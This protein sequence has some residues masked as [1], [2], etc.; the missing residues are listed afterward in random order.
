MGIDAEVVPAETKP[1]NDIHSY[2]VPKWGTN[3]EGYVTFEGTETHMFKH[4]STGG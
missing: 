3:E 1:V 2:Q 4:S